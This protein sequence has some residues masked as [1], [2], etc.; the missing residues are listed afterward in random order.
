[1]PIPVAVNPSH[2]VNSGYVLTRAGIQNNVSFL[3]WKS[4]HRN[5]VGKSLE[6][7]KVA[8]VKPS[9]SLG[10]TS[11]NTVVMGAYMT[12]RFQTSFMRKLLWPSAEK[13]GYSDFSPSS[14][15]SLK[16]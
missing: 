2:A 14:H 12:D 4:C 15:P 1:M 5:S 7:G 6:R 9:D 10:L 3:P 8:A 11:S 13:K 16:L